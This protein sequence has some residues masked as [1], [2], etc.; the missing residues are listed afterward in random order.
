MNAPNPNQGQAAQAN[1]LVHMIK[2]A[3]I[4]SLPFIDQANRARLVSACQQYWAILESKPKGSAEYQEAFKKLQDLT[5]NLKEQWRRV[6]ERQVQGQTGP[7]STMTAAPRSTSQGQPAAHT[8]P[9]QQASGQQQQPHPPPQAQPRPGA[10]TQQAGQIPQEIIRHVQS[11]PWT[12][13]PDKPQGTPEGDQWLRDTKQTYL[14]MLVALESHKKE[15][16][17]IDALINQRRNQGQEITPEMIQAKQAA[18]GRH[19]VQQTQLHAFRQTQATLREKDKHAQAQASGAPAAGIVKTEGATAAPTMPNATAG[20]PQ[21]FKLTMPNQAQGMTT[22][23]QAQPQPANA[24]IN[25][26]MEAARNAA[27]ANRTSMSPVNAGQQP[28]QPQQPRPQPQ[29]AALFPGA[30]QP[31]QAGMQ[32][33][34]SAT[35]PQR[36]ALNTQQPM[37]G[38]PHSA[39][40]P[41]PVTGP[42]VPLSHAAAVNAA[43]RSHSDQINRT[44]P[45]AQPQPGAPYHQQ[46]LGNREHTTNPRMPIP[47][48]LPPTAIGP[49]NPVSMGPGRPTLAGPANGVGGMLGQPTVEKHAGVLVEGDGTG[50]LS[51]NKLGELV[52]EVGGSDES[53]TPEVEDVRYCLPRHCLIHP[54]NSSADPPLRSRRVRRQRHYRRVPSRQAT[55]WRRAPSPRHPKCARAQLQHPNS[56]LQP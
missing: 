15:V 48:F 26:A 34:Q 45:Q 4:G 42:P 23:A 44:T 18:E 31:V 53:L 9:V 56:R 49:P 35:A 5:N 25:P 7:Q 10:A 20:G 51:K 1:P 11:I 30:A 37:P 6:K 46:Q 32:Q 55:R 54:T 36:P 41:T 13:P 22:T 14:K 38:A 21:P 28:Q 47:K 50:V 52:R 33:P 27:N 3:N 39:G 24:P 29:P 12:N 40:G 19:R 16:A 43:A 17:K 8:Q 2:P